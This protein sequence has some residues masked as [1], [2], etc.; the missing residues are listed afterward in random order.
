M[1][2]AVV[3]NPLIL[4][5]CWSVM[6]LCGSMWAFTT[7]PSTICG[8]ENSMYFPVPAATAICR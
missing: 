2:K 1:D 8:A 6:G 4:S 3:A 7:A 5:C